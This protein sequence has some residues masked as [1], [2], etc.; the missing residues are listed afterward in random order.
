MRLEAELEELQKKLEAVSGTL[1][2]KR[3][4]A[5]VRAALASLHQLRSHL[6]TTLT[7]LR[8]KTPEDGIETLKYNKGKHRWGVVT[9]DGDSQPMVG[10][11]VIRV[12]A[13]PPATLAKEMLPE[14]PPPMPL[15]PIDPAADLRPFERHAGH[16]ARMASDVDGDLSARGHLGQQA[17]LAYALKVGGASEDASVIH[18]WSPPPVNSPAT[19]R[20][21]P[22]SYQ[23]TPRS[24]VIVQSQREIEVEA[25]SPRDAWRH[26]GRA[27]EATVTKETRAAAVA[28]VALGR[29]FGESKK[30]TM[31][32]SQSDSVLPPLMGK[33]A[34]GVPSKA[35][36]AANMP[37][38]NAPGEEGH[39][40]RPKVVMGSPRSGAKQG[41]VSL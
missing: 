35:A 11:M 3:E 38:P 10:K 26:V 7:G 31:T 29:Q 32:A 6:T 27:T 24:G 20:P 36:R 34:S 39:S 23:E 22:S 2:R 30:T 33:R 25:G 4:D 19:A 28:P 8:A 21:P 12:E 9:K 41:R 16:R 15:Q 40:P 18:G 17:A 14:S 5:L 37:R 13:P 1:H